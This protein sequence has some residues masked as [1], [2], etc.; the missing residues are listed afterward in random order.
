M[1]WCLFFL[2]TKNATK[3]LIIYFKAAKWLSEFLLFSQNV[4]ANLAVVQGFCDLNI[5]PL[6][7]FRFSST[8]WHPMGNNATHENCSDMRIKSQF[9]SQRQQCKG[10]KNSQ[11]HVPNIEVYG[12]CKVDNLSQWIMLR[13]W[14]ENDSWLYIANIQMQGQQEK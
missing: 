14:I 10:G 13:P 9:S 3:L 7:S 12:W 2:Y 5:L 1:H 8:L 11:L 6:L 4:K